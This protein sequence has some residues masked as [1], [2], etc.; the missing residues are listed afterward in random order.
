MKLEVTEFSFH[1]IY[2]II[3]ETE[4]Q[5]HEAMVAVPQGELALP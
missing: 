5:R 4:V 3:E 2:F 1:F